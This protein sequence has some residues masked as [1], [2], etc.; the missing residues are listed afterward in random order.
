MRAIE[1]YQ[2]IPVRLVDVDLSEA[3]ELAAEL[4]IYAYDAYLLRCAAKYRAP[5][6]TLDRQ[7]VQLAK[8]KGI[9]VLEDV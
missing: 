5:L 2:K 9:G 8:R 4:N 7:L 6:L 3:L 1:I